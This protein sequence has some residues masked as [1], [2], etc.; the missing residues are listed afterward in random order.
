MHLA[1]DSSSWRMRFGHNNAGV[2]GMRR[3]CRLFVD[4]LKLSFKLVPMRGASYPLP[5]RR[6]CV[7]LDKSIVM[8]V[9]V[10]CR[11]VHKFVKRGVYFTVAFQWTRS[12]FG[13]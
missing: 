5:S 12:V 13:K 6:C 9:I 2:R 10:S 8:F 11:L 3:L 4:G 7:S 1:M